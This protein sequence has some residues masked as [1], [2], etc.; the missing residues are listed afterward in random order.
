MPKLSADNCR[1]ISVYRL[2]EWDLFDHD[3][4]SGTIWWS[5]PGAEKRN[6][7]DYAINLNSNTFTLAYTITQGKIDIEHSYPLLQTDCNYGGR[8]YW[9]ECSIYHQGRYCGRRVAK[10]YLGGGGKYFACRYCYDLT[11][12]S[13]IDGFAYTEWHIDRDAKKIGRWY[14]NGKLTRK[15]RSLMKKQCAVDK[16]WMEFMATMPKISKTLE[17]DH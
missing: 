3:I 17:V 2:K 6:S 13:R 15:H 4:R 16:H 9:F 12:D 7:V 5:R 14:Y 10:L 1:N 11:Y 8:R